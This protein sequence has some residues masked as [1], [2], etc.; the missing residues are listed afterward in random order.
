M[1]GAGQNPLLQLKL[2]PQKEIFSNHEG[3]VMQFI[4]T[5]K[6]R[7]KLCL[8][9][10]ILTQTQV[11][12][13][14]SGMGKLPLK[15]IVIKDNSHL[16]MA[17]MQVVWLDAG[18]SLTVRANLKRFQFDGGANWMPGEYNV[19][20]TFDLC[21]QTPMQMVTDPGHETPVK[22]SRQG[23]FMIIE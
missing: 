18:Q 2:A 7:T 3:L 1:P 17:P 19:D 10:D 13:F 14:Q 6:A 15:P 22:A 8:D 23:W 5:A 12:I 20:A 11:S 4:F 16:F 9:K 21:E